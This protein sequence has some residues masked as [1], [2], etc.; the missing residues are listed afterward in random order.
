[1]ATATTKRFLVP[2]VSDETAEPITGSLGVLLLRIRSVWTL[3]VLY[4]AYAVAV[5]A[6]GAGAEAV[7]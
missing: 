5:V 1:M 6:S 2:L 7:T 4:V 3:F